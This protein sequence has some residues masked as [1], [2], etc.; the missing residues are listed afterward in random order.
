MNQTNGNSSEISMDQLKEA[1]SKKLV[2]GICGILLGGLG[3]HKFYL[4]YTK[5][6]LITL[7][8]SL[9]TCGAGAMIMGTI[10]IIE[11]ITY[12]TKSDED[13]YNTYILNSKGWF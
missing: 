11:G 5:Q 9:V 2:A 1:N 4:G 7:A 6:G 13:F 12:L 8:I 10:G 3:I